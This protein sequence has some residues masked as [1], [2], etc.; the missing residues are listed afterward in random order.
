[1]ACRFELPVP[2]DGTDLFERVKREVE[3]H[4]GTVSVDADMIHVR[5]T[6]PLGPV[7]ATARLVAPG[8]VAIEIV[9]KPMM[10][11]CGMVRDRL[12]AFVAQAGQPGDGSRSGGAA[13]PSR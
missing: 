10:V 11:T 13:S 4:G 5:V 6:T 3:A 9:R 12:G 1:M 2:G 7:Q 8:T